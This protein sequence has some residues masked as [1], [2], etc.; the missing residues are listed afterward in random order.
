MGNLVLNFFGPVPPGDRSPSTQGLEPRHAVF[1]DSLH[2]VDLLVR[3][4]DAHSWVEVYFPGHGWVGFDPTPPEP[5]AATVGPWPRL[6]SA[7]EQIE[8]AWDT[9]IVGLDIRD[10]G[11]VLI[12]LRSAVADGLSDLAREAGQLLR[13]A[14][15]MRVAAAVALGLLVLAGVITGARRLAPHRLPL[16]RR[17]RRRETRTPSRDALAEVYRRLLAQLARRGHR[18]PAHL[19]PL[20]FAR[21]AAGTGG[22]PREVGEITEIFCRSRYG[23]ADPSAADLRHAEALIRR[24]RAGR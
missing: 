22:V 3:Q 24:I 15:S 13:T 10:Q 12:A 9:W 6:V 5:V 23:G 20:E 16:W 1:E 8:I 4:S 19:T 7:L 11:A 18:R 2:L 21:E 17:L 14:R